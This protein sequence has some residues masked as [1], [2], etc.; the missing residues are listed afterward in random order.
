MTK[1]ASFTFNPF[2]ENTYVLYDDSG[3]CVIIDPGCYDPEEKAVL[4]GFV[5]SHHLRPVRLLNTHC[6]IDHV[7]GNK[8]AAES[9]NLPLECHIAEL[10]LLQFVPAY[11]AEMGIMAEPSPLPGR[12]IEDGE[13]IRFGHTELQAILAPGHSPGSLCFYCPKEGFLIGGDVLFYGSVG[14]TDLP[15]GDWHTLEA[16]IRH[17]IFTLPDP[18]VVYPGHDKVTS[19]GFERQNN[20][21]FQ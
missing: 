19:V 5:Q 11:G 17:R 7:L 8:F 20:P 15:G 6:H 13:I 3:E 1:I 18:T 10:K 16:S 9:W 2:S 4:Y 14:R 12:Y 21:F